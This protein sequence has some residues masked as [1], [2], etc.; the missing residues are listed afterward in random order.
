MSHNN[1][2]QKESESKGDTNT[3]NVEYSKFEE[4]PP[5]QRIQI[6]IWEIFN[7]VKNLNILKQWISYSLG[8][9]TSNSNMLGRNRE[10]TR[11]LPGTDKNTAL[12]FKPNVD[13]NI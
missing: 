9:K 7:I 13:H 6:F 11:S 5:V 10:H 12:E 4:M 3:S 8:I 1:I 2:E